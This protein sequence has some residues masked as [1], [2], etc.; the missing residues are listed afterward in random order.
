MY[1]QS[2]ILFTG[3]LD[4]PNLDLSEFPTLG[5]RSSAPPNPQPIARNYGKY[6]TRGIF[7]K[8]SLLYLLPIRPYGT[9]EGAFTHAVSVTVFMSGTFDILTLCVNTTKGYIEP[10]LNGTKNSEFIAMCKPALSLVHTHRL[11]PFIV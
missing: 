3:G 1:L 10:I 11:S 4:Q 2:C 8:G 9:N 6:P 7:S 5:N